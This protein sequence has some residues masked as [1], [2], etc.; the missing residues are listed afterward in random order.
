MFRLLFWQLLPTVH[1]LGAVASSSLPTV[2]TPRNGVGGTHDLWAAHLPLGSFLAICS[3]QLLPSSPY[4]QDFSKRTCKSFKLFLPLGCSAALK[5]A[6][7]GLQFHGLSASVQTIRDTAGMKRTHSG[8]VISRWEDIL[9]TLYGDKP[10]FLS[11]ITCPPTDV[12][13]WL[14]V[15]CS[16]S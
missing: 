16:S 1:S 10:G 12:E 9:V 13:F 5:A 11:Q 6:L 14:T 2:A 7:I 3:V 15:L 4:E 8:R